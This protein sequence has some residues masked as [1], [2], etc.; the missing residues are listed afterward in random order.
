MLLIG[1]HASINITAETILI[2]W[3]YRE[4]IW[5][6]YRGCELI[7]FSMRYAPLLTLADEPSWFPRLCRSHMPL[8]YRLPARFA[9]FSLLSILQERFIGAAVKG[10]S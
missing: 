3:Y 6:D 8:L 4:D 5:H 9:R 7:S 1:S 10:G 2:E